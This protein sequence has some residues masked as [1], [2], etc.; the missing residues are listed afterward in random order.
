M[1]LPPNVLA[2]PPTQVFFCRSLLTVH[3]SLMTDIPPTKPVAFTDKIL[4][5]AVILSWKNTDPAQ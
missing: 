2:L 4:A 1:A 3:M 5:T